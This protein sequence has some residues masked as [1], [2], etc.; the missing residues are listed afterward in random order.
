MCWAA[1]GGPTWRFRMVVA[2]ANLS[3]PFKLGEQSLRYVTT[4]HGQFTNDRL[5]YID[6]LTIGSRYTV[7]GFDGENLLAGE[8]GFYWRNELQAPLG[9]SGQALYAGLEL[10]FGP[11]TAALAGTQLAGAVIGLR[12]GLGSPYGLGLV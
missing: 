2:D 4:F 10:V 1:A 9:G 11:T 12:G 7:R 8:R 3:A 6:T 5:Y